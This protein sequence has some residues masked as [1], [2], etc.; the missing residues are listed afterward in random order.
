MDELLII[1]NSMGMYAE[2]LSYMNSISRQQVLLFWKS[3]KNIQ[4]NFDISVFDNQGGGKDVED[5]DFEL[6]VDQLQ[7]LSKNQD[8]LFT[9]ILDI[10]P[11]LLKD[12][13]S[14]KAKVFQRENDCF[15]QEAALYDLLNDF[16][17][18]LADINDL[19]Y[20]YMRDDDFEGFIKSDYCMNAQEALQTNNSAEYGS[21]D[22][23]SGEDNGINSSPGKKI[24]LAIKKKFNFKKGVKDFKRVDKSEK[25]QGEINLLLSED[26]NMYGNQ[27]AVVLQAD[28]LGIM[29]HFRK[30]KDEFASKASSFMHGKI[31]T[32]SSSV[33]SKDKESTKAGFQ[34]IPTIKIS[35]ENEAEK[36]S[37]P[38]MY[39]LRRASSDMKMVSQIVILPKRITEIANSIEALKSDLNKLRSENTANGAGITGQAAKRL[40]YMQ[41]GML[42][43]I[44]D[45]ERERK[46]AQFEEYDNII[47]PV[48]LKVYLELH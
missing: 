25:I 42:I 30:T 18:V 39:P 43:E 48:N 6:L 29:G 9:H 24:A 31:H 2:F 23:K 8:L 16:F 4:L 28:S 35:T 11:G 10:Q 26:S 19:A 20:Q 36:V 33:A 17:T 44:E 46:R 41:K 40:A 22:E 15:E 32:F 27:P 34:N 47:I 45:L 38:D 3:V 14:L 37:K 21:E 1:L 13:E 12:F 5:F 7:I